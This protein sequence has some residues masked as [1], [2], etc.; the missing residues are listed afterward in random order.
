[1]H[2]T[3][4]QTGR[5]AERRDI[6]GEEG[7]L[8]GKIRTSFLRIW[9]LALLC[10]AAL[11]FASCGVD[12]GGSPGEPVADNHT[13]FEEFKAG[14]PRDLESGAYIVEGDIPIFGD[15][16]LKRYY[17]TISQPGALAVQS[18]PDAGGADDRWSDEQKMNLTYCVST[19]FGA[20]YE[21]VVYAMGNAAR[22]WM[23]V[24]DVTFIHLASHDAQCTEDNNEVVFNVIPM[25]DPGFSAIAFFPSYARAR[26]QL[27]ID[28][29]TSN[30]DPPASVTGIL[31]HEL[32]H[33]LGFR[34]EH[35]RVP[36]VADGGCD[37]NGDITNWRGLTDYDSESVMHYTECPGSTSVA[38][39]HL[40]DR[41]KQG[42]AILYGRF[43]GSSQNLA[44]GKPT[45]QSSTAAGGDSARAVDDII[46][47]DYRFNSVTHTD[48]V[49]AFPWWQV[50]LLGAQPIGDVVLYNRTD[51][52][53][54]LLHNFDLQ[55]SDD[56][57]TWQTYNYPDIAPPRLV[58][59]VNRTARYV[60]V[61]LNSFGPLSL[62]EVQVLP[63]TPNLAVGRPTSQS[64]TDAGGFAWRA[65]DGNPDG[66]FFH[67]SVTHTAWEP[68]PWW[69][70]DLESLQDIG[71][72][73]LFNRT[74]CCS[75]RLSNFDL[76]VSDDG[77]SWREA[78]NYPDTAPARVSIPV[79]S[80]ARYVRVKL[81]GVSALNLAEVQVF[82]QSL[83]VG[84]PTL[85]SS[86]DKNGHPSRAVDNNIDGNYDNKSV[87]HTT[88]EYQPRWVVDLQ[89]SQP[90][91]DVV[92]YNR[93]DGYSG[94]LSNFVVK[95]SDDGSNWQ[96]FEYPGTAPAWE[97]IHVNR[98]ARYVYVQL[99]GYGPL[100]LAEVQVLPQNLALGKPT[101]QSSTDAGGDPERAVDGN[102]DGDFFHNSVT[103]TKT[104]SQ[105]WW[106]V[107]LQSLQFVGQVVLYNRTDCCSARL[108]NFSLQVS[109][110]GVN[111]QNYI[112]FLGTAPWRTVMAVNRTTRY[113]RV[114]LTSYEA[115]SL[116]EVQVFANTF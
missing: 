69:R 14:L 115:L 58:M 24:A 53:S 114:Q 38:D 43:R 68:Q 109:D 89:S 71:E 1:M 90:V 93:T 21:A 59:A 64:S 80:R 61:K 20:N 39:F 85:Q 50:D 26:R 110:D 98:T 2:R 19:T 27:K 73:V 74:D 87:T 56:G 25:V 10:L 84:R 45:S 106:Q 17:A 40:T 72:V 29:S 44:R 28:W 103:H 94:R 11:A 99:Y 13:S 92:L 4:P 31:R 51:C 7:D 48:S 116:A 111:W 49:V 33:T 46:E 112:Y 79:Y 54:G 18:L 55:V 52:C 9:F 86:I 66:D 81:T 60:R 91:G 35:I 37:D 62:A 108:S 82:A 23:A 41:D 100:S 12:L 95:V 63:Q 3:A 105:P 42:A 57:A 30:D 78:F 113:V 101:R 75:S 65:T 97:T 96:A 8:I 32:G 5:A 67:D 77:S 107:D 47:G 88:S 102:T 16:A 76:Q 22:D 15:E 6:G 104:E 36:Q 83:A 70:V 34:H